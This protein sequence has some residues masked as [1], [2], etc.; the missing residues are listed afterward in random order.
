M[1]HWPDLKFPPINLWSAPKVA[2]KKKKSTWMKGFILPPRLNDM[3]HVERER[4]Q[5]MK[6]VKDAILK[7][8]STR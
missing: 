1:S 5:R 3:D 2:A 4:H 6:Q 8:R 7:Q